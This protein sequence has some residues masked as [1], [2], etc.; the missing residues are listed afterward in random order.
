MF[1]RFYLI[2]IMLINSFPQI[3]R[4]TYI[5]YFSCLTFQDINI[6]HKVKVVGDEL[7]VNCFRQRR[8]MVRP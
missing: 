6:E 8:T 2:L 1:C 4:T 7:I 5:N 3:I